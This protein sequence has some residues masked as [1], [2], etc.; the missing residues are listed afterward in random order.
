MHGKVTP[1]LVSATGLAAAFT[2]FYTVHEALPTAIRAP[3]SLLLTPVAV[4]SGLAYVL[5]AR[6]DVYASLPAV[7]CANWLGWSALLL[8]ASFIRARWRQQGRPTSTSGPA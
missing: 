7:F 8:G 5:G 4:A 1:L 2:W 3:T 6:F